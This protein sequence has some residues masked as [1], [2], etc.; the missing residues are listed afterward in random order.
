MGPS[1]SGRGRVRELQLGDSQN[2]A[3]GFSTGV[4]LLLRGHLA[5]YGDIFIIKTRRL[6]GKGQ[7]CR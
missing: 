7:G 4:I 5:T 3:Q 1:S 2:L 6:V